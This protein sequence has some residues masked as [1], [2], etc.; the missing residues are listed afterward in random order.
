MT[1]LVIINVL[2]HSRS[3]RRLVQSNGHGRAER[4]ATRTYWPIRNASCILHNG[5]CIGN[6]ELS[7]QTDRKDIRT[8]VD[9]CERR[10]SG[11]WLDRLAGEL[12]LNARDGVVVVARRARHHGTN[13]DKSERAT[14]A[15]GRVRLDNTDSEE[16]DVLPVRLLDER[17]D[18]GLA[19]WRVAVIAAIA[20]VFEKI[21]G[22]NGSI[23][24][25]WRDLAST[26]HV[27]AQVKNRKYR[28][29]RLERR[30]RC[31]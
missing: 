10:R 13:R 29:S 28:N 6:D 3:R 11:R 7:V 12:R 5:S 27:S 16:R 31:Q 8:A 20:V 24:G 25:R 9:S 21:K 1:Q 2:L 14:S 15:T 17:D 23:H 22:Q 4:A 30:D 18:D 19:H 26:N